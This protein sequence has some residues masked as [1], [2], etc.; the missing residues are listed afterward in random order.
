MFNVSLVKVLI[1]TPKF[2]PV[3]GGGETYVLNLARKL[4]AVG[5]KV[6]VVTEPNIL[7]NKNDYEFR[8]KEIPGFSDEGLDMC[9]SI[10]ELYE[11]VN[12][13][14]PDVI[15]TH[16]YFGLLAA[17]LSDQGTPI[18]A[19]V[20]SSPIPNERV[21]GSFNNYAAEL[22]FAQ[23][24]VRTAEPEIF[25]AGSKPYF[26]MAKKVTAGKSK[27]KLLTYPVDTDF[28]TETRV[29]KA[30]RATLD[31]DV[32]VMLP[33][34]IIERKGIAEAIEA[35]A[36]LDD[37]FK[38]CLPAAYMPADDNFWQRIK[39]SQTWKKYRHRIIV[40]KEPVYYD[41]LPEWYRESDIIIMP[42]YYEGYGL[43]SLE[44][45]SVGRPVIGADVQGLNEIIEHERN[46][47]LIPAKNPQALA[48]AITRLQ[49]DRKLR[50]TIIRNG[51]R[52]AKEHSWVKHLGEIRSVYESVL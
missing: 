43:S 40:P 28:F 17:S 42:S 31:K 39:A 48:R 29:S 19:S 10:P 14:Q 24:V 33:S 2:H 51:R 3:I 41:D 16:G 12:E 49:Q 27:L 36:Y 34:R 46:G 5:V 35:L 50:D 25:I 23:N 13:F 1:I 8:V 7:R 20:H 18:V 21:F 32:V 11:A 6:M 15:H 26:T 22:I 38:L 4:Y 9:K 30:Q 45:M 47:L 52:Y 37:K 44:A